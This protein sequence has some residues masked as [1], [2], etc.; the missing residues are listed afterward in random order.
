MGVLLISAVP[1]RA[2]GVV[3]LLLFALATAAS[4]AMVSSAVGYA[5]VRGRTGHRLE[6]W[7]PAFGVGGVLFGVWYALDALGGLPRF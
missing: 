7:V 2:R 3:A 5:L 1:G 4:M 6:R